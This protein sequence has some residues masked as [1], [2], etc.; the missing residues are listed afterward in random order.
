MEGFRV[1]ADLTVRFSETDAQGIAHHAVYLEWF[2]VARLAYIARL[3][4]GYRGMVERGVDVTTVEAHVRYRRPARFD[5]ALRVHVRVAEVRGAR[6]RFEYA[7]ERDGEL[8]ADGW[9]VHA[10]LD[11]PSQ[12]PLR[13][14]DDLRATIEA[15]EAAAE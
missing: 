1:A 5:D 10:C 8:L 3:P 9:S 6:F 11:G 15:I 13:L 4:G 7:I 14:P 2:E 12:R